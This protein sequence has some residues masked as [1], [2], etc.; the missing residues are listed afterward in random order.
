MAPSPARVGTGML[1]PVA[2]PA[3]AVA[4]APRTWEGSG[5]GVQ[6]CDRSPCKDSSTYFGHYM[7]NED[8]C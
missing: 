2:L 8:G 6:V 7:D 5:K 3:M 4:G 1:L